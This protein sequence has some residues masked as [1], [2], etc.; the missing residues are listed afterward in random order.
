[1]I[2]SDGFGFYIE[3]LLA[4]HGLANVPVITNE[5][6]WNA[7]GSAK[8]LVF[9]HRNPECV[10]CGTCKM[11][12]VVR[13]RAAYGSVAFVGEGRTDRYGVLFADVAFA[14]LALVQHCERDGVR[15][16]PWETFDDVRRS[17]ERDQVLPGPLAP[18]RCP[19]WTA[20]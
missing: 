6:R 19:G 20:P 18:V 7:D 10:G 1:M 16:R 11:Q 9:V 17:L 12:A 13:A 3:P 8:D 14:K 15:Y 2:V 4:Q 5:Q